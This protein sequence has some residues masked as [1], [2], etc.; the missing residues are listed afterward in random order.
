MSAGRAEEGMQRRSTAHAKTK[1]KSVGHGICQLGKK[2]TKKSEF[3]KTRA[4]ASTET[5]SQETRLSPGRWASLGVLFD[6]MDKLG[7]Q[8]DYEDCTR[9]EAN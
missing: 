8:I 4:E 7:H 6:F 1:G 3:A 2:A 9:Q 5:T